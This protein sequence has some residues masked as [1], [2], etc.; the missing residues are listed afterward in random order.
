M[1]KFIIV[2]NN[3]LN[4]SIIKVDLIQSQKNGQD[5]WHVNEPA[6]T[7]QPDPN[8]PSYS[9]RRQ[10]YLDIPYGIPYDLRHKSGNGYP[11]DQVYA[12]KDEALLASEA[13]MREHIRARIEARRKEIETIERDVERLKDFKPK[14]YVKNMLLK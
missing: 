7:R 3:N 12:T 14:H 8:A 4:I 6:Y 5:V 2:P 10:A 11:D 13:V 9:H 1:I